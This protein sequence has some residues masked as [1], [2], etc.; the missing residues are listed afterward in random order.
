MR[1]V[2]AVI[3]GLVSW[4]SAGHSD[5]FG[6]LTLPGTGS[7]LQERI[8]SIDKPRN[9]NVLGEGKFLRLIRRDGWEYVERTRPI[10]AVFIAAVTGDAASSCSPTSGGPSRSAAPSSA[11]PAGLVGDSEGSE[12]EELEAAT[13]RELVEEAGYE[14]DS[15]TFLTGGPT[16]AGI[17]DEVIA[18]ML[19]TGLRRVGAGG[20]VG[21]E[22]IVVH[23]VPLEEVA[24]WLRARV[25]EGALVNPKVYTGLYFI[26][27]LGR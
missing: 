10:R 18:I 25:A 21:G 13:R 5:I 22:S 7:R 12:G 11:S 24:S 1:E 23:E 16:S 4:K 6:R 3:L 27:K 15:V 19:A 20:G 9:V 14:P 2:K 17:T 8:A 26:E